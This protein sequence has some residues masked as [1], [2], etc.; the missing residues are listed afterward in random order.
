MCCARHATVSMISWLR[1]A[2]AF[3]IATCLIVDNSPRVR[4]EL[5]VLPRERVV[6]G[7][8]RAERVAADGEVRRV[9]DGLAHFDG[10]QRRQR[11][12]QAVPC[13]VQTD[14]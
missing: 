10:R 5:I 3:A 12:T 7:A 11:A 1:T 14:I 8:R 13:W 6:P 4:H 2:W 9:R